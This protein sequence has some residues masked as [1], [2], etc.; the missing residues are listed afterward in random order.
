[1]NYLTESPHNTFQRRICHLSDY[2]VY[3][4]YLIVSLGR[5]ISLVGQKAIEFS[6]IKEF[7]YELKLFI[8]DVYG[9]PFAIAKLY[10]FLSTVIIRC[11]ISSNFI[12]LHDL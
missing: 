11:V 10:L 5:A 7:V 9:G 6:I 8:L 4:K 2:V 12:I 1:M 3:M